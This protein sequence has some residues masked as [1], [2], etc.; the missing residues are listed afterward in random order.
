[1]LCG[2]FVNDYD[3]GR[4][5]IKTRKWASEISKAVSQISF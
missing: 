5:N 1:M 2:P 4:C 3:V